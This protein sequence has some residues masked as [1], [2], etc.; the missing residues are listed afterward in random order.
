MNKKTFEKDRPMAFYQRT[1]KKYGE[2]FFAIY[3][4]AQRVAAFEKDVKKLFH[5]LKK[6]NVDL[7]KVVIARLPPGRWRY[8]D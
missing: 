8:K 7:K 6:K 3:K 4:N 1:V 5:K 2:G